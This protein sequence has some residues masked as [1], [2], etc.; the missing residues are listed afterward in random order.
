[1]SCRTHTLCMLALAL[2]N[3]PRVKTLKQEMTLLFVQ[4]SKEGQASLT[5]ASSLGHWT[6]AVVCCVQRH[7]LKH[8]QSWQ[9]ENGLHGGWGHRIHFYGFMYRSSIIFLSIYCLGR[10][11]G[12]NT[13]C[14]AVP[15]VPKAAGCDNQPNE[16]RQTCCSSVRNLIL[17]NDTS[18]E[19]TGHGMK[20]R[21]KQLSWLSMNVI[22][23][24]LAIPWEYT[25]NTLSKISF[26][27]I[28]FVPFQNTTNCV[29]YYAHTVYNDI[30]LK[31]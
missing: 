30:W 8:K 9:K 7:I 6:L 29:S 26:L 18:G 4:G 23:P 28:S 11:F 27:N 25:G 24:S 21:V 20:A 22:R 10:S 5:T 31:R 2:T 12:L 16:P 19:E 3:L 15:T 13:K 1:M 14:F 17:M